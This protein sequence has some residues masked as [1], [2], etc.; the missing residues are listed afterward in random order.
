MQVRNIGTGLW[1]WT[2]LH[3]DWTPADGGPEGW[4]QEV[5]CVYYEADDAVV[6]IDPLVPPEDADRFYAALDRD[7]ARAGRPVRILMTVDAHDRSCGELAERYDG[8]VGERPGSVEIGAEAWNEIVYWIPE[9]RAIVAGDV[10]ISRG[11]RLE[12]PRAWVG[13]DYNAAVAD[14]RPLLELPVERV[15]VTHGDPVLA[16]AP[17]ALAGALGS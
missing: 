14:L 12:V 9:H 8:T 6:L 17:E 3:P 2:A 13:N 5:G 7:V 10:L 1:H 15:L 16:G 11:G 4:E